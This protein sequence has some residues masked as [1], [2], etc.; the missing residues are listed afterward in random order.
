MILLF[1]QILAANWK[2]TTKLL[3]QHFWWLCEMGQQP[4][5]AWADPQLYN[6]CETA[7]WFLDMKHQPCLQFCQIAK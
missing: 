5:L 1:C 6:L 3:S 2:C 4:D 7:G